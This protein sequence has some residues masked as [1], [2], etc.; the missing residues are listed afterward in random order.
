MNNIPN[1][2]GFDL[3]K[4]LAYKSFELTDKYDT[5]KDIPTEEHALFALTAAYTLVCYRYEET[6]DF[7]LLAL[8]VYDLLKKE[9]NT[10]CPEANINKDYFELLET[11]LRRGLDNLPPIA[12][13][14]LRDEQ[15]L[16]EVPCGVTEY[17]TKVFDLCPTI[18][19]TLR[20][21]IYFIQVILRKYSLKK[22]IPFSKVKDAY[23]AEI[24][25]NKSEFTPATDLSLF[26]F[27]NR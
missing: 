2:T 27:M 15:I 20:A 1:V 17:I 6:T 26:S 4:V 11:N 10:H 25:T 14:H 12:L 18:P 19:L 5:P 21:G 9:I 24:D 23:L 7:Y 3:I 13:V 8:D 22:E 16:K